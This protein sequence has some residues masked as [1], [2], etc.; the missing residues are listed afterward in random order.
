MPLARISASPSA[1]D[2]L[3]DEKRR[4]A[5]P[6]Q[7]NQARIRQAELQRNSVI[8]LLDGKPL[9]QIEA[10]SMLDQTEIPGKSSNQEILSWGKELDIRYSN[11]DIPWCG[12]FVAHC[13]NTALPYEP[14]IDNVLGARNWI[15]FGVP[16][17][18]QVGAMAVF[19]RGSKTSGK[20][21][22]GF[23]VGEDEQAVHVLGG[24]QGNKVSIKRV[25]KT[26]LLGYRWPSTIPM[27]E[28]SPVSLSPAGELSRDEQ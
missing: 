11:D 12:L 28:G 24:N 13:I 2:A 16:T 20:G 5:V 7:G 17:T 26:R 18:A 9:W 27:G 15:K 25:H 21:H 1:F 6:N 19:W 10:E 4:L 22:V 23:Y 14:L 8:A 3:A